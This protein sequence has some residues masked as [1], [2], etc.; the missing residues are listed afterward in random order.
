MSAILPYTPPTQVDAETVESLAPHLVAAVS[1]AAV[2]DLT[3]E[4]LAS[5]LQAADDAAAAAISTIRFRR[6]RAMLAVVNGDAAGSASAWEAPVQLVPT[7]RPAWANWLLAGGVLAA[8]VGA[9]VLLMHWWA[10]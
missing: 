6:Q 5:V 7:P 9:F 10:R 2:G 3:P 4:Q 1:G 8:P